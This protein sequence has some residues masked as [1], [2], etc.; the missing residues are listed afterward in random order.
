MLNESD[1]DEIVYL[2]QLF[3][4]INGIT[5]AINADS[6]EP[7]VLIPPDLAFRTLNPARFPYLIKKVVKS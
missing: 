2:I 7:E 4:K 6:G 5:P 1:R 3:L